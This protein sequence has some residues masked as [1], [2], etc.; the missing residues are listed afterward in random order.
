[1]KASR[2]VVNLSVLLYIGKFCFLAQKKAEQSSL[3]MLHQGYS[4]NK[5]KINEL[6]ANQILLQ[7]DG[8]GPDAFL[9][10]L[11][12]PG[13]QW[14]QCDSKVVDVFTKGNYCYHQ[15]QLD[16]AAQPSPHT[17]IC[18][19]RPHGLPHHY[20]N[21]LCTREQQECRELTQVRS[22]V[23]FWSW[24]VESPVESYRYCTLCLDYLIRN[25]KSM[26]SSSGS[27]K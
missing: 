11:Q 17:S 5:K 23:G 26:K 18:T 22:Q 20:I 7:Q 9:K 6:V 15:L 25:K 19:L 27:W 10:L 13:W 24:L 3:G 16:K 1:M 4:S 8:S 14:N 2:E 21:G 12:N